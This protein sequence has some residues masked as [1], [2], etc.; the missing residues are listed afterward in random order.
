M[1]LRLHSYER[2]HDMAQALDL[3]ARPGARLLAGGTATVGP[4]DDKTTMLVDLAG[5]GLHYMR[6][7]PGSMVVGAMTPL[8]E[9][10]LAPDLMFLGGGT[11]V[12]A[13]ERTAPPTTLVRATIGGAL[14]RPDRAPELAAVLLALDARVDVIHQ[15]RHQWDLPT[16]FSRLPLQQT[17]IEAVRIPTTP[18]VVAVE[19]VAR[20]PRDIPAVTVVAALRNSSEVRL[21]A[22]GLSPLPRRFNA[23]EGVPLT[24]HRIDQ[25]A[26]A[27]AATVE[28]PADVR[29]SSRYRTHLAGVLTRRALL[30]ASGLQGRM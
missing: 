11:L 2:P 4:V 28:P 23:T 26:A 8:E 24:P 29:G 27:V 5:L 25:V 30:A 19:R 18:M 6:T 22:A 17:I 12:Q 1:F 14:A 9:L 10:M 3:L 7:E 13:V 15:E 21:A 20:T 16:L